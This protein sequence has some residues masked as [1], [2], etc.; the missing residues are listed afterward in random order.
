[1][2]DGADTGRACVALIGGAGFVGTN[3]AARLAQDNAFR[4]HVYDTD[5]R[6]L[7]FRMGPDAR[8]AFT[9]FDLGTDDALLDR[10]VAGADVVV[11]LAALVQPKRFLDRPLDMVELNLM[12]SLKVVEACRRHGKRLIHFST[13]EVYGKTGGRDAPFTEDSTDCILG[14]IDNHRWIY[15]CAKQMLDRIIHAH[16]LEGGL[17]YT[18][19]RPFNFVGALMDWLGPSAEQPRVFASFMNALVEER[20]LPLVDGGT[21]RRCFT[22]VEDAVS[23]ITTIL[24]H[25]EET[26]N[27]IYNVGNPANEITIAGLAALMTDLFAEETGRPV[28]LRTQSVPGEAFY[29]AGYEDCD[30]RMP[31]ISRISA[32]GW[33]PQH[34]LGRTLRDAMRHALANYDA[35]CGFRPAPATGAGAE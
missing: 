14:P 29:G 6:K 9:P 4:P 21:A 24:A 35:L 19:I 18:L 10:A 23:A 13:S 16:G 12:G 3:L 11:N 1:M 28:P 7:A 2:A 20:P 27:R 5:P 17:H 15:S 34:D 31:D 22:H 33:R 32:L 26:R 8:C 25:P 30:R